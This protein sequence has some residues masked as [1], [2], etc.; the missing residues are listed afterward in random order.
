MRRKCHLSN[1]KLVGKYLVPRIALR[2]CSM[3]DRS[4]TYANAILWP[5]QKM[6]KDQKM[7]SGIIDQWGLSPVG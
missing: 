2:P 6:Q 3:R 1:L 4:Q 7:H 5:D